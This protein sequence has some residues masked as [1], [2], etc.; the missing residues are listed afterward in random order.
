MIPQREWQTDDNCHSGK[1]SAVARKGGD[2]AKF[3][4]ITV[5]AVNINVPFRSH[6]D[7][8]SLG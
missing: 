4:E 6:K 8:V 3:V 5:P 7:R 1:G 2:F